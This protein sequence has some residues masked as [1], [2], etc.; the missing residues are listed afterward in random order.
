[1]FFY[2]LLL[3]SKT[4][5]AYA[6]ISLGFLLDALV[7]LFLLLGLRLCMIVVYDLIKLKQTRRD[8]CRRVLVYGTGDKSV[9]LVPRLQN[10]P[11]YRVAGFLTYGK[12]LRNH[13]VAECPVYY[14]ENA[15]SMEYLRDRFDIDAVLFAT[16]DDAQD[17]QERLINYC[18]EKGIKVLIVP[19]IDEVIDGKIMKQS[20]R[21]IKIE[22][23]LGR[24]E[25]EISMSEIEANFA[26]KTVL[27]TGAAGSIGSGIGCR[28]AGDVRGERTD[29]VRQWGDADAQPAS[30]VGGTLSETAFRAGYRGYSHRAAPGL[31]VPDLPSAGGISRCGLQA[32]SA[33]GRESMRGGVGERGGNAQRGGQMHWVRRG[34]DGDDLDGQ[35]REPDERDGLHEAS[36]GDLCA[37]VGTGRWTEQ[38]SGKDEIRDDALRKCAGLE[39]KRYSP[40]PGARSPK[41]VR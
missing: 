6:A 2:V 13:T 27:V 22:D 1:M 35:G 26:G 10:S 25:I 7:T 16:N 39:R 30:G 4:S 23:L 28:P 17:E 15:E 9:S 29:F 32:C 11:H 31:R 36:G 33:D 19:P 21:E 40:L 3:T 5:P 14:F 37:V 38:D 24:P 8:N 18:A 41:A 20:I 12:R 34:E